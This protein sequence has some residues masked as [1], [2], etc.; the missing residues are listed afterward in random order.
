M[1]PKSNNPFKRLPTWVSLS[2]GIFVGLMVARVFTSEV[3]YQLD[4]SGFL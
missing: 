2:I 4:V 1:Q 3:S